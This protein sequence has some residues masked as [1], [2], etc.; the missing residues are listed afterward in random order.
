MQEGVSEKSSAGCKLGR[1]LVLAALAGLCL[2]AYSRSLSLPFISDDYVQIHLARDYGPLSHWPRLAA[3]ALYR[4]RATSLILTY[5]TEQV[6]GLHPLPYRLSSL[7]LHILNTWLV[8][9]LGAWRLIGFR[10]SLLAA[11]FFAV[12]E[13][14]QEA[15]IWYA[16]LPELLVFF[17]LMLS[18]A[19]WQR[20]IGSGMRA[21]RWYAGSLACFALALLSKE[22]AVAWLGLQVLVLLGE[23]AFG[24]KLVLA[25]VPFAVLAAGYTLA[26]FAERSVHLHFN[27]GTFSLQAPFWRTLANSTRR[28]L[29][30]W[31]FL[32]LLAILLRQAR[33]WRF[34]LG[35]AALWIGVSFLPYSFL[36]YMPHVPSRHTYLASVGLGWLVGAGYLAVRRP[37]KSWRRWAPTALAALILAHNCL[38]L[39]T[40]KQRQF[41]ERAAPTEALVEFA[42]RSQ[43]PVKVECF[44]YSPILAEWAVQLRLNR[45]LYGPQD[46]QQGIEPAVFCWPDVGVPRSR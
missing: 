39:W 43:R 5:W 46:A 13:G 20:W 15:V 23:R 17:F 22:S 18:L 33:R 12:H 29:W 44:P 7:L 30:F 26:A 40:R 35:A 6:F 27:D 45:N 34:L 31:G 38:Y 11:A 25:L 24:R 28:L 16:A 4:C 9:W 3:D 42:S 14:H 37:L 1:W 21:W 36:T 10:L 32:G 2:L 8:Y 41:W 19:A